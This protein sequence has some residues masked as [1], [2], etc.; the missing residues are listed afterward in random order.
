VS[1]STLKKAIVNEDSIGRADRVHGPRTALLRNPAPESA[2]DLPPPPSGIIPICTE[3]GGGEPCPVGEVPEGISP[4]VVADGL[5]MRHGVAGEDHL[6][7]LDAGRGRK[8][9]AVLP[10][11]G[12]AP[13]RGGDP[14]AGAALT[15]LPG[16]GR[17]IASP[18]PRLS[19]PRRTLFPSI[20]MERKRGQESGISSP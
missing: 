14:C 15:L 16:R 18:P 5:R 19:K 10:R 1:Q 17:T 13:E 8:P 3:G 9:P 12:K 7:S 6:L 11:K 2:G 4:P 20:F